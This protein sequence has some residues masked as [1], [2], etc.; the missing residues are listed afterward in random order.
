MIYR[1]DKPRCLNGWWDIQ[2][3]GVSGSEKI[4][5]REGWRSGQYLVPSFYNKPQDAVRLPGEPFYQDKLN[6]PQWRNPDAVNDPRADNLLDAYGYPAEWNTWRNVWVG[7]D[8]EIEPQPGKRYW[9]AAEA[10]GPKASLFVN[11]KAAGE[12]F[13]DYTLPYEVDITEYLVSGVNR[14][15]FLL[16]D[17]DRDGDGNT[18]WPCGN[19]IPSAMRGLWQDVYLVEKNEVFCSDVTI[20]TSVREKKLTLTYE[21]TNAGETDAAVVIESRVEPFIKGGSTEGTAGTGEDPVAVPV[22]LLTVPAHGVK[23]IDAHIPWENPRLW[24]AFN[25]NLYWLRTTLEAGGAV[26][27]R[28]TDRFG[29]REIRIEGPDLTL[30]GHPLHLFADWGHKTTPFNHTAGW[31]AK[32]FGMIRDFNM[33]HSRLHTHPHPRFIMDMADEYG[34]YITAEAGLHGAGGNQ[35]AASPVY[36]ENARAHIARFVR[37][38]KNHPSVVLWSCENEMRWNPSGPEDTKRELPAI[39]ALFNRLDP[40]R[41]AYH[42]GD[43]SLWNEKQQAIISRHYGKECSGF[44]WWDKKQPLHSGEMCLY[45]YEGPNN[46]LSLGGDRVW[47]S[48]EQVHTAATLDL[49]Y[50]VEDAR[51][52][53]VCCL[54][55]WNV[56]CLSNLRRHGE[57]KF[58]YAD[59]T[60]PGVKPLQARAGSSEFTYWEDGPGYTSQPGTEKCREAFRPFAVIDLSRRRSFYTDRPFDRHFYLVNDSGADREGALRVSLSREGKEIA[61]AETRL[62]CG[63]GRIAEVDLSLPGPGKPGEYQYAAQFTSAGEIL[64]SWERSLVFSEAAVVQLSSKLYVLGKGYLREALKS[65]G[66]HA[67]YLSDSGG[68][69]T[70]LSPGSILLLEKNTVLPGSDL[71]EK[72]RRFLAEGG[73]V[74]V[75]EQRTSLFTGVRIEDKP[76]QTAFIRAYHDP[77]LEGLGEGDL[78]FWSDA[79]YSLMSADNYVALRMYEKD[80]GGGMS[81]LLDSGEGNFGSGRLAHTPLFKLREGTGVLYANQTEITSA[82]DRVPAARKLLANLLSAADTYRPEEEARPALVTVTGGDPKAVA[83]ALPRVKAGASALIFNLGEEAAAVISGATGNPLRLLKEP[84][85]TWNGIR[86]GDDPVLAGVS[87]EDLCGIEV[88]SYAPKTAVNRRIA[89]L[90]IDGEHS[91]GLTALVKTVPESCMVPLYIYGGRSEMLRAYTVNQYCYGEKQQSF[92]LLGSLPYGAGRLFISTLAMPKAEAPRLA[93]LENQMI[94]NL[95]GKPVRG[96]TLS[97]GITI[98]D[99]SR[100]RGYPESVYCRKGPVGEELLSAMLEASV[101]QNERMNAKP[102]LTM[103]G[104]SV[105]AGKDG[106]FTADIPEGQAALYYTIQSDTARKNLSSNLGIPDPTAQT[107]LDISGKGR[108]KA[109][110]N[111][112]ALGEL[113]DGGV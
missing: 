77:A 73:R 44:G 46:T 55:P 25:P 103:G 37:R 82:L 36:W 52:N 26:V 108:V 112:R 89:P 63:R 85:G 19:W 15:D 4:P 62:H 42:E 54:G 50:T 78:S 106:Q 35:G 21:I 41:P 61:A 45:H 71:P 3:A 107:F 69:D 95:S 51:A 1:F 7:R 86:A 60:S 40:T 102:I 17:Y 27:D 56:S 31:V 30:N 100:S 38:D 110:L 10:A 16:E 83:E 72:V 91:P 67:E 66:A 18:L 20:V 43:S 84:E 9:I 48:Y 113:T 97:Q 34:I 81:F 111:G 47:G 70:V 12:V 33:N 13:R 79:P 49:F 88:F 98:E 96:D 39:R 74:I 8:L 59:Y 11:G 109:W 57:K 65:M 29:F 32:W 101:Y 76:V 68:L 22:L 24:D 6:D 93:R 104:F 5:P 75:M 28:M 92:V 87:N 2:S 14:L 105:L 90:V 80:D 58:S 99:E 64:D 94:Q 53:G 23:K